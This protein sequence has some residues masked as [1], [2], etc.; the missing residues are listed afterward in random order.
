MSNGH[1]WRIDRRE[2][3]SVETLLL[4]LN[5]V[6]EALHQTILVVT[7]LQELLLCSH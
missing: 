3:N 2:T 5:L 7:K 4:R 6:A 1:Y